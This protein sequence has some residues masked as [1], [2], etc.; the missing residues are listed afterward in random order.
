MKYETMTEDLVN[1]L[2]EALTKEP[3][4]QKYLYNN[5]WLSGSTTTI[6]SIMFWKNEVEIELSTDKNIFTK[7]IKR[8]VE[9]HADLVVWGA[10]SKSDGSCPSTLSFYYNIPNNN[11]L[12]KS[13]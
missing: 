5:T 10:F 4:I 9:Q 1:E 12:K 11:W 13:A 7:F 6:Y 3:L 8:F 2:Y